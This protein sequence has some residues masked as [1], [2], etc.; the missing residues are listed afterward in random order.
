MYDCV[1]GRRIEGSFGC[2]MGDEMGLGKTLQCITL[3][4]TLLR[5]SPECRPEIDRCI[6]VTPSSLVKVRGDDENSLVRVRRNGESSLVKV[7]DDWCL[8]NFKHLLA[9]TLCPCISVCRVPFLP[10]YPPPCIDSP[11]SALPS[12]LVQRDRQVAVGPRVS[13]GH[14]RRQSYGGGPPAGGLHGEERPPTR[15][16][17]THHLVRDVPDPRRP[18]APRRGRPCAL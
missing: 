6:V 12:E 5:Q 3:M 8:V 16:P 17:H 13:A 1:T 14:G 15:Q 10:L 9:V 7:R 2:I 4:W 11:L 18:A